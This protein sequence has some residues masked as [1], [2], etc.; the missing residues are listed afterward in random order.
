MKFLYFRILFLGLF[1]FCLYSLLIDRLTIMLFRD[2]ISQVLVGTNSNPLVVQ[3]MFQLMFSAVGS[4][5]ENRFHITLPPTRL[6]IPLACK[7]I[8]P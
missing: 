6:F 3:L 7:Y 2:G 8:L 5:I 1:L 4:K